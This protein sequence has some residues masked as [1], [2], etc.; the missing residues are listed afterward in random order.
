LLAEQHFEFHRPLS[1]GE[2]LTVDSRS[3]ETWTKESARNGRLTFTEQ[4]TTYRIFPA[5]WSS[6]RAW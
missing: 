1:P 5:R 3:G 4:I 2:V 6:R